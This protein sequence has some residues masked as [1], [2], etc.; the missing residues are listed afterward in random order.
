MVNVIKPAR[1][2]VGDLIGIV[3][4][5]EPIIE[6]KLERYKRGVDSLKS[7]GF[8]ILEGA[9]VLSNKDGYVSASD[10]QRA[11]D[12]NK[13]FENPDVKAILCT[14][15]GY[16]SNGILPY[17]D[18]EAIKRN[19]KIFVGLSDPTAIINAIHK[20]T[21]IVT[22]HGPS[23]MSDFGK[24]IHPYTEEYFYRT[25]SESRAIGS[26]KPFSKWEV[27]KSGKAKG[28]LIGGNL[29]TLQLL[30]G[31]E[32]EPN[33]EGAILFWEDIGVE[34]HNLENK[35]IQFRQ[36]GIL[37]KVKG[38][39]VGKCVDC[40]MKSYKKLITVPE[41]VE[42]VCQGYTFPILY[43][44][45]LGHT[46]EKITIPLGLE[47]LIDTSSLELSITESAVI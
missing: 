2:N 6:D 12:I 21:G 22:F 20:K 34:P 8:R 40:D 46:R 31:T 9:H 16:N 25:V 33:W 13:M 15:G 36:A 32:Y 7:K 41:I 26:I 24:G 28:K 14:T 27:I 44:I 42:K 17:L 43:N 39:I 18:Y 30:I 1:L 4:P 10:E 37:D 47:A 45:D 38:M 19:P 29:S 23:V 3:T 11:D 35:L 5:S